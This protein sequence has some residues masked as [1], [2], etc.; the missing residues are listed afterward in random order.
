MAQVP[1]TVNIGLQD[2]IILLNYYW[3]AVSSDQI[4]DLGTKT[5]EELLIDLNRQSSLKISP[6]QLETLVYH[7]KHVIL[8]KVK[9]V[10]ITNQPKTYHGL[11]KNL[12]EDIPNLFKTLE[13]GEI[14]F[15]N[16][17]DR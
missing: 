14:V 7:A 13:S 3:N 15:I 9:P 12:K 17:Q 5:Y 11:M 2:L 16:F 10:K 4:G 6:Q 1:L 8:E